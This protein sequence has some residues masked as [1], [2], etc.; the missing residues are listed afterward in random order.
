MRDPQDA[1][2]AGLTLLPGSSRLSF[3][4]GSCRFGTDR[5]ITPHSYSDAQF[6]DECNAVFLVLTPEWRNEMRR[7]LGFPCL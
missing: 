6:N 5:Y 1:G 2:T 3:Y 4:V 7:L